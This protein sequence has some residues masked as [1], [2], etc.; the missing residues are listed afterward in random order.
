VTPALV[1][2]LRDELDGRLVAEGLDAGHLLYWD[3][4]EGLGT[5]MRAW[6]GR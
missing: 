6:L 3:A 1:E 2:R 4:R 5:F